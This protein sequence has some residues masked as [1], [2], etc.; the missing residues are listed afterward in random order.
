V[1]AFEADTCS[2]LQAVL[3]Q[4][5]YTVLVSS[6]WQQAIEMA[7]TE[8][9]D[10]ILLDS[11]LLGV[12]S[13]ETITASM[14]SPPA[15]GIPV[16]GLG[17]KT[18][19]EVELAAMG[20]AG[21]VTKPLNQ[22]CVLRALESVLGKPSERARVLVVEDDV[23]LARVLTTVFER[24]GAVVLHARTGPEAI[25]L[26]PQFIPDLIVLD[27]MLPEIDGFGVVEQLRQDERLKH[28]P[29]A[30]YSVKELDDSEKARLRLGQSIFMTKSRLTPQQFEQR[31]IGLLNWA[32]SRQRE[33]RQQ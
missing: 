28:L 14:P 1:C 21:W 17:D 13:L 20:M 7:A 8:P 6:S 30:V 31:V 19:D 25:H 15:R 33:R 16:I 27:V 23:D 32:T 2:A 29:L 5:S 26:C 24:H 10:A 12:E 9:P 4:G 11:S 22:G 18:P 3:K